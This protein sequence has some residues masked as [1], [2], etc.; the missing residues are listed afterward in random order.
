[1]GSRQIKYTTKTPALDTFSTTQN[2]KTNPLGLL[3]YDTSQF[4]NIAIDPVQKGFSWGSVE[5]GKY[6]K[7]IDDG[8]WTQ[9]SPRTTWVVKDISPEN[10]NGVDRVS[11]THSSHREGI[12]LDIKLPKIDMSGE[13]PTPVQ[14]FKL[15]T[16]K[17]QELD[18]DKTLA[19]MILSKLYGAKVIFLDKKF[20]KPLRERANFIATDGFSAT[21]PSSIL[22]MD[23]ALK[24]L[25]KEHLYGKPNFAKELIQLLRHKRRYEDHF[26]V[27]VLRKW[28]SH[29]TRDYPGWAIKRLKKMGCDYGL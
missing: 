16:L 7:G 29:E 8:I 2:C 1:V 24:A 9:T 3:Q 18:V 21:T 15:E 13:A 17:A 14:T 23:Q 27:R 25:F 5:A 6:L 28:G 11:S 22:V 20:F 4:T 19:F 10:A 26:Q 12:D